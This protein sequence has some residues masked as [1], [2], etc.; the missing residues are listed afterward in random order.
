MTFI[1]AHCPSCGRTFRQ[2]ANLL[3]EG[4]QLAC[5]HCDQSWTLSA[6][7]PID[8]IH[9]LLQNGREA[10]ELRLAAATSPPRRWSV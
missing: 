4:Q 8:E 6:A 5:P 10:R 1:E 7:S 3:C 9:R 2:S